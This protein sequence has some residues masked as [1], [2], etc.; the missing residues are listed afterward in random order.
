MQSKEL[1]ILVSL[2]IGGFLLGSIMFSSL[3][4]KLLMG[5]D[6]CKLGS[7]HNPG[8]ANVFVNCGIP[9]GMLCLSLDLLKGALPVFI[10]CKLL[11]TSRAYFAVIMVAP[12]LGHAVGFFN[13]FHG[14][15]CIATFFG[16]LLGML[17]V[18]RIVFLL[19]ILYIFFSV[20][21]KIK[22]N[23]CRSIVAFTL[24]GIVSTVFFLH[25]GQFSFAGGCSIISFIAIAKHTKRF[26]FVP[27][28]ELPTDSSESD[29]AITVH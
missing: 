24:F 14:G 10:A 16:V 11:D 22:P 19:A 26:C 7:D 5:R 23:R 18:S 21:V 27:E 8:S 9:M 20:C 4:P 3:L 13:R 1:L 2:I 29:N 12:V 6:I 25:N 17:P 15:K 28:D